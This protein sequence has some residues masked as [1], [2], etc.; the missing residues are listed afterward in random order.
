MMRTLSKSVNFI[1]AQPAAVALVEL[2]N[3][4]LTIVHIVHPHP[5]PAYTIMQYISKSLSLP[6]VSQAEW[7]RK[8]QA[9]VGP[10]QNDRIKNPAIR[11]L[12]FFQW[13]M[14]EPEKSS[15]NL[16][17]VSSINAQQGAPSLIHTE[18]LGGKDIQGWLAFWQRTGFLDVVKVHS[19]L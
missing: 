14:D 15:S 7:F 12:P 11:L 19:A 18:P 2:M 16:E 4:T 13:L 3:S 9:C 6:I 17:L 8:L 10:A 5:I 1:P